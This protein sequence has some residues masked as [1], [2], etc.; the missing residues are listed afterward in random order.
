MSDLLRLRDALSVV[1]ERQPMLE[2]WLPI[3]VKNESNQR[4]RWGAVKRAKTHRDAARLVVCAAL[5]RSPLDAEGLVVLLTRTYSGRGR[6]MDSDG[7]ARSLKACRDGVADA[8]GIDDGS[9]SVTWVTTQERG[10]E[11]GVLVQLFERKTQ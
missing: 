2:V 7:V 11:T 4:D 9:D 3:T 6:A 1:L 5:R 10:G 8:L